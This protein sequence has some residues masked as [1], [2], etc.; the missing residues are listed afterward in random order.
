M[1]EEE[2]EEGAIELKTEELTENALSDSQIKA[3][4]I[5]ELEQ[6]QTS[7]LA[8]DREKA[9]KMYYGEMDDYLD[10]QEGRS[11]LVTR[12]VLDAIESIL[13]SLI[14]IFIEEENA[15]VFRATS[16]QD[17]QQ[18]MLETKAVRHVFFRENDGFENLYTYLKDALLS[19]VGT[20]KIWAEEPQWEREEYED[21][22]EFEL[23][24]IIND[25]EIE[26]EIDE[27][28]MYDDGK[29]DVTIKTRCKY[30]KIIIDTPAPEEIGVC[31]DAKSIKISDARFFWHTKS[32]TKSE[33]IEMGFDKEKVDKIKTYDDTGYGQQ[34]LARRN[35]AE[36]QE[37][38]HYHESMR[39]IWVTECYPLVDRNGDGIAERLK[40]TLA[41]G[42][43]GD[44]SNMTL[45]D[46]DESVPLFAC[47]TPNIITH[48]FN[49]LSIAD[50]VMDV[51]EMNTVLMRGVY[52]NV[53]LANNG[54][55]AANDNVNLDDLLTKRPGGI[56]RT[57]GDTNPLQNVA[58]IPHTQLMPE[59]FGL[60]D[61]FEK[62]IRN[63]T[64]VG[65]EV[66]GLDTDALANINTG[67]IMQAYDNARMRIELIARILAET[68]LAECFK[69]I[70]RVLHESQ[71]NLIQIKVDNQW[72]DINPRF[73]RKDRKID[74]R[75]GIGNAD[76]VRRKAALVE[77]LGYQREAMQTGYMTYDYIHNTLE[78]IYLLEGN[79]ISRYF[80][81]PKTYQPPQQKPDPKLLIEAE[82]LKL[83][84]EKMQAELKKLEL[85]HQ[86]KIAIEQSKA[87]HDQVRLEMEG[88]KQSYSLQRQKVDEQSQIMNARTDNMKAEMEISIMAREQER[89]ESET[90]FKK[91]LEE[92]KLMLEQ[93]KLNRDT[94]K[95]E[96]V[97]ATSLEEK[98]MDIEQKLNQSIFDLIS[99]INDRMDAENQRREQDKEKIFNY[100]SANG[101]DSIKNF[102]GT[103]Q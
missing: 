18:A 88:I 100:L 87:G 61:R 72:I 41:G 102:M 93:E 4:C 103:L 24:K 30:P 21:L 8:D 71:S 73:W 13:P 46:I 99:K 49:G 85:D 20:F 54:Q 32:A 15:I 78:D 42:T 91:Q 69:H 70:R 68:G 94:Y 92:I 59:T 75:V 3:I 79:D 77:T 37:M 86:L 82:K 65:D 58:P 67:V 53:Y 76:K 83:D 81:D 45:I 31:G 27:L 57:S 25:P 63:R 74:V 43:E 98:T 6:S 64:G 14:K 19:K 101:S 16:Q 66:A 33:L 48:K 5:S 84:R 60:F 9:I 12:E 36:E 34:Q 22:D 17:E 47:G 23:Q 44:Y 80:P 97:S 55:M 2:P 1:I 90:I 10:V 50:L 96:L 35:Y 7:D 62:M 40:V 11:K 29:F 89:K 39:T 95:A 28:E 52:D 56:V 51:Q 26:W 38:E